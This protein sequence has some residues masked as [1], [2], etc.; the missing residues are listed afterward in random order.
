[1]TR[2]AAS[3]GRP[4]GVFWKENFAKFVRKPLKQCKTCSSAARDTWKIDRSMALR[5]AAPSPPA[6]GPSSQSLRPPVVLRRPASRGGQR[7]ARIMDAGPV[8]VSG[9]T[10]PSGHAVSQWLS[11]RHLRM[12]DTLQTF[13]N[14]RVA[15]HPVD[16]LGLG[17]G[18]PRLLVGRITGNQEAARASGVLIRPSQFRGHGR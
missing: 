1:M 8:T 3:D 7:Q 11:L 5:E 2:A 9:P 16:P 13:A 10:W 15:Q 17:V 18:V 12:G 4:R 14:G 6:P